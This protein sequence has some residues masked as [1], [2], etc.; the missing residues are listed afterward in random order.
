MRILLALLTLSCSSYVYS[1]CTPLEFRN[2]AKK[3]DF[4]NINRW[5]I[6][7]SENDR[8]E[9]VGFANQRP[10]LQKV[11]TSCEKSWENFSNVRKN[12]TEQNLTTLDLYHNCPKT[13]RT[14]IKLGFSDSSLDAKDKGLVLW[15]ISERE[16]IEDKERKFPLP[17]YDTFDMQ[18]YAKTGQFYNILSTPRRTYSDMKRA[19]EEGLAERI[20]NLQRTL[21]K[22]YAQE[23]KLILEF[24]SQ[25]DLST[26]A[27]LRMTHEDSLIETISPEGLAI[28]NN[29]FQEHLELSTNENMGIILKRAI[30][31]R[32]SDVIEDI[33]SK[34]RDVEIFDLAI[35]QEMLKTRV[36]T[37]LVLRLFAHP[38]ITDDTRRRY[39]ATVITQLDSSQ[40]N[41]F[42]SLVEQPMVAYRN[43]LMQSRSAIPAVDIMSKIP[44]HAKY[45]PNEKG[46]FIF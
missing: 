3:L 44:D 41:L 6:T 35:T 1:E 39:F 18:Y 4:E 20:K 9:I 37:S 23:L 8:Q 42:S 27:I 14:L 34:H 26:V 25:E 5:T 24:S 33:L 22:Y 17:P 45:S 15:I 19:L 38:V 46:H 12:A 31:L 32:H 2:A 13:L 7:A 28:I 10:L 40:Q 11:L 43:E 30:A 21:P 29:W 36:V 16:K